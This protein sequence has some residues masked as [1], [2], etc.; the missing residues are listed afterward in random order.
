[1]TM[2]KTLLFLLLFSFT[3]QISKAEALYN[4]VW[5]P[6]PNSGWVWGNDD[7]SWWYLTSESEVST[8]KEHSTIWYTFLEPAALNANPNDILNWAQGIVNDFYTIIRDKESGEPLDLDAINQIGEYSNN[9]LNGNDLINFHSVKLIVIATFN[10]SESN[11]LDVR[12][13]TQDALRIS[14]GVAFGQ[15]YG[16]L[17][18]ALGLL[19]T[20]AEAQNKSLPNPPYTNFDAASFIITG[21]NEDGLLF[22]YNKQFVPTLQ[23]KELINAVYSLEQS[24]KAGAPSGTMMNTINKILFDTRKVQ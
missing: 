18:Y 3:F 19:D 21:K 2:K 22:Q 12:R 7:E 1:M 4:W 23:Q 20:I 5:V 17:A 24:I 13:I 9:L 14:N 16:D 8:V 6:E 10:D 11:F 15:V